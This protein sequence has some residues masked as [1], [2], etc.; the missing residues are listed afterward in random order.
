MVMPN[1]L[2]VAQVA[3]RLERHL[4]EIEEHVA[5]GRLAMVEQ[6]AKFTDLYQDSRDVQHD[7]AER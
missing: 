1:Y 2:S 6:Y 7:E 5:I 3:E 4:E